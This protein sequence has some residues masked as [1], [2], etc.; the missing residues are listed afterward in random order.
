MCLEKLLRI[1]TPVN[2]GEQ[3]FRAW[4]EQSSFLD[5]LAEQRTGRSIMYYCSH[6]ITWS[7]NRLSKGESMKYIAWLCFLVASLVVPARLAAGQTEPSQGVNAGLR[8]TEPS[9][10]VNAGL[11]LKE[12]S[13]GVAA[14]LRTLVFDQ[15]STWNIGTSGTHTWYCPEVWYYYPITQCGTNN[16]N[17]LESGNLIT[18]SGG[19]LELDWT[20]SEGSPYDTGVGTMS[21]T[22]KSYTAW[23][24]PLY[25]EVSAQLDPVPGAWPAIWMSNTSAT[26]DYTGKAPS[27]KNY[28][29]LDMME[30]NSATNSEAPSYYTTIHDWYCSGSGCQ[31]EDR[32]NNNS[33]NFISVGSDDMWNYHTWGVLMTKTA[34]T[35]YLDNVKVNE[36][37]CRD[38]ADACAALL[39]SP[40]YLMLSDTVGVNWSGGNEAPAAAYMNIQWVHVWD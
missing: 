16:P 37:T 13:Q 10:G 34:I 35:W 20:S 38:H 30:G 17:Y 12:P 23:K 11:R 24:A 14:G 31:V 28:G 39:G 27:T 21:P 26:L 25:I 36:V 9:Q 1:V 8:Q 5:L 6:S 32:D 18:V 15:E 29:E 19:V 33:S 7:A 40:L 4:S 22:G 3:G 2:E